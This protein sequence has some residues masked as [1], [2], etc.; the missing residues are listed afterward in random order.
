MAS[1]F[2]L[3]LPF[4]APGLGTFDNLAVDYVGHT[5]R[6]G[7]TSPHSIA[8]DGSLSLAHRGLH[9]CPIEFQLKVKKDQVLR[10][11]RVRGPIPSLHSRG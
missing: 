4:L 1:P 2:L 7:Q 8:P 10:P 11:L 5:L 3:L 9:D 6:S